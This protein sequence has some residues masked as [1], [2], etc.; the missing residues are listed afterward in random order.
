MNLYSPWIDLAIGLTLVVLG[1]LNDLE[2]DRNPW[3][4]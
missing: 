2:Q 4:L 1:I 3:S